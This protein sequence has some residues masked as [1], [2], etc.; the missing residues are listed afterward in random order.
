ML[1]IEMLLSKCYPVIKLEADLGEQKP[2]LVSIRK[3]KK[4]KNKHKTDLYL[5]KMQTRKPNG[6]LGIGVFS[7]PPQHLHF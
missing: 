7:I 1:T 4:K 5:E 6:G 2:T 3:T